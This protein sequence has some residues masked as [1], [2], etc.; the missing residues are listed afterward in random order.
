MG[1]VVGAI[2]A[3]TALLLIGVTIPI[4]FVTPAICIVFAGFMDVFS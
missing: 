2:I 3:I 4:I 1:A